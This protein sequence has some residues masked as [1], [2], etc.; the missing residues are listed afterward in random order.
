M[1]F[2]NYCQ[3]LIRYFLPQ[4]YITVIWFALY[5]GIII[6]IWYRLLLYE[7]IAGHFSVSLKI[8]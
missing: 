5:H 4:L 6:I 1:A 8:F 3:T 7:T 2:E